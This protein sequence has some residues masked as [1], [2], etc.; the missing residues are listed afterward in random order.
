MTTAIF[1]PVAMA[2]AVA[3]SIE[4]QLIAARRACKFAVENIRMLSSHT[5]MFPILLVVTQ[6][7]RRSST[8]L[9]GSITG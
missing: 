1:E 2:A 5:R 3:P 4:L 6:R 9:L 7:R 8:A